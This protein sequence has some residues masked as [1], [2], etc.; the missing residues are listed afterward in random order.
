MQLQLVMPGRNYRILGYRENSFWSAW[1]IRFSG[2]S[3]WMGKSR[4]RRWSCL[5]TFYIWKIRLKGCFERKTALLPGTFRKESVKACNPLI[6]I[7]GLIGRSCI[8]SLLL[9]NRSWFYLRN[10]RIHEKLAGMVRVLLGEYCYTLYLTLDLCTL[11]PGRVTFFDISHLWEAKFFFF[12]IW[13]HSFLK[14]YLL[15]YKNI[16]NKIM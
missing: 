9:E 2:L 8:R 11:L 12:L 1:M 4:G 10:E 6:F 16:Y 3:A 5:V 14:Q 7:L 15:Y 13:S